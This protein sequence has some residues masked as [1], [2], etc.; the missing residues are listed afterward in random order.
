MALELCASCQ[1]RVE[2]GTVRCPNCNA[3]LDL[4]GAFIHVLGWVFVAISTVPFAIGAAETNLNLAPI[5]LGAG[6]LAL[7]IFF[8]VYGKVRGRSAAPRTVPDTSAQG[9][10]TT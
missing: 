4:P 2:E 6:M 5:I 3:S 10:A 8:I 1:Q 9:P 7:G